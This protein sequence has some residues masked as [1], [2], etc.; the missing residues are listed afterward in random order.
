MTSVVSSEPSG[1]E[2]DQVESL[3]NVSLNQQDISFFNAWLASSGAVGN[4]SQVSNA[5]LSSLIEEGPP[6]SA[7]NLPPSP[8]LSSA[9]EEIAAAS[10]CPSAQPSVLPAR[11]AEYSLLDE[12]LTLTDESVDVPSCLLN[13]TASADVGIEEFDLDALLKI[14]QHQDNGPYH[15]S[16]EPSGEDVLADLQENTITTIDLNQLVADEDS[17]SDHSFEGFQEGT[18][19]PVNDSSPS[20]G[21]S[22]QVS[23]F[24]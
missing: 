9:S 17:S 8:P 13:G 4:L 22:I 21:S 1:H 12:V 2:L 19:A 15:A 16:A 5:T 10:T 7:Q 6:V 24:F 20:A 11:S 3:S 23:C 18:Q 14:T